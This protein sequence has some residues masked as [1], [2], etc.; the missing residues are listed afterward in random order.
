MP[1]TQ[2]AFS[3]LVG[4]IYDCGQDPDLW[5]D[6][7]ARLVEALGALAGWIGMQD[8]AGRNGCIAV[9]VGL[10]PEQQS[11]Y[12]E[13]FVGL[14]PVSLA[15][16]F[17]QVG[18]VVALSELVDRDAFRDTVFYKEWCRPQRIEDL[19]AGILTKSP[20][21]CGSLSV[22]FD[23]PAS[24]EARELMM[25]LLPH[26]RR[27]VET[28][29]LL[30]ERSGETECLTAAMDALSAGVILLDGAGRVLRTNAAAD[31]ILREG[32]ALRRMPAGTLATAEPRSQGALEAALAVCRSG[33]DARPRPA[34]PFP[35]RR[36]AVPRGGLVG[37]LVPL[38]SAI[39]APRDPVCGAG[40]DAERKP[41]AALFVQDPERP[42][43]VPSEALVRLYG[44]TPGEW[45]VLHGLVQDLT[46]SEIAEI[47]GIGVATVRTHLARLFDKT[48]TRRQAELLRA[49]M[50]AAPAL[51][52]PEPC[53]DRGVAPASAGLRARGAT[54]PA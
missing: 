39:L 23:R 52:A 51:R 35:S 44:L 40:P 32:D 45:R 36:K 10:S 5:P 18:S 24:T 13:R 31:A 7:L 54:M 19:I 21:G 16:W 47:Y 37:Q 2:G 49:V 30:A 20:A 22:S 38:R 3:D 17:T 53:Q 1:L 14:C 27:A 9:G 8:P 33:D 41:V 6:T 46:L 11:L 29:R 50:A 43:A 34:L 4:R 25:L 48:G 15:T 12:A 42:C 28:G 26:L